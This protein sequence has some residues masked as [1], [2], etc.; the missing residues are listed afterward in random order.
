MAC[1]MQFAD[2]AKDSDTTSVIGKR[3]PYSLG[4]VRTDVSIHRMSIVSHA[5]QEE[6]EHGNHATPRGRHG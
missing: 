2:L 5:S 4:L 1:I 6:V 3:W